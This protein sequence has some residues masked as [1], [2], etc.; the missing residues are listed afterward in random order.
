M[1]T[2]FDPIKIGD[3]ELANRVIMAPLTRCRAEPGRVPGELIAEYYGQRAE[4]GAAPR[5]GVHVLHDGDHRPILSF[6][7]LVVVVPGDGRGIG[8]VGGELRTDGVTDNG[9]HIRQQAA[10]GVVGVLFIWQAGFLHQ[11]IEDGGRIKVTQAFKDVG[12]GSI[13]GRFSWL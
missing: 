1:P 3:L 7:P 9:A 8:I 10:D 2:L 13:H 12:I 11:S 4:A 5:S 6:Q